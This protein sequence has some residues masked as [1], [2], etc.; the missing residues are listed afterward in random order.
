MAAL[1][2]STEL[3][4]R[5]LYRTHGTERELGAE[6]R[7]HGTRTFPA[8]TLTSSAE[9]GQVS[10][11]PDTLDSASVWSR[12]GFTHESGAQA[13]PGTESRS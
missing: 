10:Q 8:H 2:S 4:P 11:A 7:P 9:V 5:T 13:A 12:P 6:S 1:A 3:C